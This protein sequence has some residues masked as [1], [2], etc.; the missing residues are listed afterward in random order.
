MVEQRVVVFDLETVPDLDVGRTLLGDHRSSTD[1]EVR[2]KLGSR[3]VRDGEDPSV[4]FVKV[5]LHK[6]VCIGALYAERADRSSGWAVTR[7]GVGH[8][9]IRSE[10]QLVESFVA[11][12]FSALAESER[13]FPFRG[14]S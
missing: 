11:R 6:I 13:G 9:G 10:R 5:P 7:S 3:Y 14:K 12:A 8:V 2:S 1:S 4:A